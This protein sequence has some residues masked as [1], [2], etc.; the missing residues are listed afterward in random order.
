MS[1]EDESGEDP[2]PA[3]ALLRADIVVQTNASRV[4]GRVPG[5]IPSK[6]KTAPQ[7]QMDDFGGW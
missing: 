1:H 4:A 2:G 5:G 7:I 3:R 6:I